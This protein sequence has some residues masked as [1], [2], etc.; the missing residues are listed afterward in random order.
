MN[1]WVKSVIAPVAAIVLLIVA[2]TLVYKPGKLEIL[3]L[4]ERLAVLEGQG[5]KLIPEERIRNEQAKVDSLR[6]IVADM[7]DRLYPVAE[8]AELGKAIESNGRKFDL[9]LVILTP[10]Y[11]KLNLIQQEGQEITELPITINMQG[12]F[13]QFARYLE[14]LSEFPYVKATE[15]N[16]SRMEDGSSIEIEIKGIVIFKNSV[17]EPNK[18]KKPVS[19]QT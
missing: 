2:V 14:K 16:L 19:A 5:E 18:E 15:V 1:N 8:F 11:S 12:R 6:A 17:N 3:A 7:K 4:R 13:M 10:D 9:R